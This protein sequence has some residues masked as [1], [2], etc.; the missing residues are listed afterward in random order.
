MRLEVGKE[1]E[2]KPENETPC[3]VAVPLHVDSVQ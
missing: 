1:R 3:V 2:T